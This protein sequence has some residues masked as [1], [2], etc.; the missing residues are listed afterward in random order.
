MSSRSPPCMGA[1]GIGGS[2]RWHMP[3]RSVDAKR[4]L[5][6][7]NPLIRFQQLS[8]FGALQSQIQPIEGASAS[9][10]PA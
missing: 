4:N 8:R 3:P 2:K 7:L 10:A 9:V 6:P 5:Q 1:T